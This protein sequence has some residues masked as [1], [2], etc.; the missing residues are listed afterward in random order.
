VTTSKADEAALAQFFACPF[1]NVERSGAPFEVT[2]A[3]G[4]APQTR[5][6]DTQYFPPL[7]LNVL[8]GLL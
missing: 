3:A 5:A 1:L 8:E 2:I 6:F 7:D 4:A